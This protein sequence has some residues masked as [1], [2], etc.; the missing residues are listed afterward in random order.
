MNLRFFFLCTA[1]LVFLG[2]SS[3]AALG[4]PFLADSNVTARIHGAT[5]A[6][7]TLE[8]LND[9]VISINSNPP[10]SI[11]AKNGVYAFEL[12][13]GDYIISARY[14]RNN[15]L[16]YSKETNLKIREEG[17]YVFDLLLYP[18][19]ENQTTKTIVDETGGIETSTPPE[20]TITET[21]TI[22]YPQILLTLF[23]LFGGIYGLSRKYRLMK[24]SRYKGKKFNK[25]GLLTKILGK[26]SVSGTVTGVK[27]VSGEIGET[28]SSIKSKT[29][30]FDNYEDETADLKNFPLSTD[31]R[32]ILNIIRAHKG[33]ITQK[34]LR[35]RLDYSEVKV[36][37][38]LSELEKRGLIK[39]FKNGRENIIVLMDEKS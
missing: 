26:I 1:I 36:S 16:I 39:K 27:P 18:V 32:G 14:Y 17:N 20:K 21:Y 33:R 28:F 29:Q 37:L 35:R 23:F 11:V 5:Y 8:P 31:L 24:K 7:D 25:P 9:T 19:S 15:T 3:S 2:I 6:L 4:V 10:Q 13:P 30:S 12:G 22:S 34:E 38:L